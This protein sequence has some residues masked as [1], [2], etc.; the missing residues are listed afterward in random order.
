MPDSALAIL[1]VRETVLTTKLPASAS[2]APQPICIGDTVCPY[3]RQGSS[4]QDS[5]VVDFGGQIFIFSVRSPSPL[6]GVAARIKGPLP[7]ALRPRKPNE[8]PTRGGELFGA[9]QRT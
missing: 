5:S 8:E 2:A 9:R 6:Q 3:F 7:V 4:G 1:A